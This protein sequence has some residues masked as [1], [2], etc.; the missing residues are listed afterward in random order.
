MG[1]TLEILGLVVFLGVHVFV[2]MRDRRAAVVA[3]IGEWPYRALFSLVSI[4]GIA[5]PTL[6]KARFSQPPSC[7]LVCK[8]MKA[9]RRNEDR[10]PTRPRTHPS[11][12][13]G[14]QCVS[15]IREDETLERNSTRNA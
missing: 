9:R 11:P 4:L 12:A 8:P 6:A 1:L 13:L 5:R 15:S 10:I 7:D 14:R 2:T 3:Q